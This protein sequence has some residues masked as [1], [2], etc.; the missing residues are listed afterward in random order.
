MRVLLTCRPLDCR[1]LTRYLINPFFPLQCF[2]HTNASEQGVND[3]YWE[4][5]FECLG[6]VPKYYTVDG[7]PVDAKVWVRAFHNAQVAVYKPQV[8]G[9]PVDLTQKPLTKPWRLPGWM[10][11][12][13]LQFGLPLCCVGALFAI[14]YLLVLLGPLKGISSRF[15]KDEGGDFSADTTDFDGEYDE[16]L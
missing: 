16:E 11:T 2:L 10:W 12:L 4:N 9:Q 13:F 1:P 15:I 7:Q 14:S 8:K 6:V 5:E 3:F